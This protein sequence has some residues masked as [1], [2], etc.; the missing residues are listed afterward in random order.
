MR[1]LGSKE[2]LLNFIDKALRRH[3][4]V[5]TAE[6]PLSLCDPFTGT[7]SV[8]RHLK[9]QDWRVVIGRPDGLLVC[10]PARLHRPE[11]GTNLYS[12]A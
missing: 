12:F 3:S 7:T 6:R 5:S 8:A 9:R 10:L 1:Y 4:A 11:R 2:N